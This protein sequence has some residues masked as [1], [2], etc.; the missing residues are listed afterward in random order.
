MII[1]VPSDDAFGHYNLCCAEQQHFHIDH[2]A[3][4][5]PDADS[6]NISTIN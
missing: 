1:E 5:L 2:T 4:E 3:V 6:V